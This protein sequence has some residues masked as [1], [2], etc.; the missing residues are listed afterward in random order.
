MVQSPTR[1][2][3]ST[4]RSNLLPFNRHLRAENK[5][6]STITT[7]GKAVDQ[8]GDFLEA[9]GMP[10]D[11]TNIRREHVEAFP[12]AMQGR[13]ARPATVSQRFRSRQQF[14][15]W[16]DDEGEVAGSPMARMRLAG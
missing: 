15:R 14:F 2:A 4:V 6:P 1:A 9:S 10:V 8:L 7:N 16:L 12:V 3:H 5:A 11:V 13:G